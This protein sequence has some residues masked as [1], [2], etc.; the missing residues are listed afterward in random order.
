[1]V[2]DFFIKKYK[3]NYNVELTDI[4]EGEPVKISDTSLRW[5]GKKKERWKCQGYE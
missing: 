3:W 2:A 1:M 4:V 5:R